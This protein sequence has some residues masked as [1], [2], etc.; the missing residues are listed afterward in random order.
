MIL[1]LERAKQITAWWTAEGA[2]AYRR[3]HDAELATERC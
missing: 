1:V 3:Q 2:E